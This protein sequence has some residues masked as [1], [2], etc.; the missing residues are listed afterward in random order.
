MKH[1]FIYGPPGSGKSTISK[2]LADQLDLPFLDLDAEIERA[3]G[4]AIP[5]IMTEQ[6]EPAFRD[7]ET[8]ALEKAVAGEASIIALG[9]GALLRD[10]NRACAESDG[11]VVLLEA[12]LPTLLARTKSASGQRP[13][14]VGDVEE[15]LSALMTRRQSHY[16]SFDLR[17]VNETEPPRSV[18]RE[19]QQKLGRFH[20]C[21]MGAG[22]DVLVKTGGLNGLGEMLQERGLGGPIALVSDSNVAPLYG[23]QVLKS[24]REAGFDTN[25]I[26]IPAGEHNKTFQTVMDMWRGFLEAGLDRKSTVV[27]L[28]GGVTGDLAGFAASTFMRGIAWVGL[29]TSLLAM[30]DSALGGKTGFD[31]PYGKNLVGA[32]HSPRLVLADPEVLQTLPEVEFRSGMAEVVKHGVISDPALFA[33][34]AAGTEAV[35][36]DLADLVRHS[37]AVKI[38]IIEEDPFERGLRAALN[39]GHTVGHAI[40]LVSDFKLR[41]GEAVAIGMVVEAQ[42]AERLGLAKGG[43]SVQIAEA[44]QALGLPVEIP[45]DLPHA[46]ILKAI[47]VDK[48]KAAGVVRFAL[49]VAIGEVRTGV[50]IEDLDQI[51]E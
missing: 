38:R 3:A 8:A 9:G 45:P 37:M 31:L 43:L 11:E 36:K 24:V 28:G 51:F 29:P 50:E 44:L 20:V 41:H 10:A 22:Y 21:G 19:I 33:L 25:L 4:Q 14:L 15:K 1:I 7:L 39:L 17:V 35:K 47:Q 23:E 26:T 46:D 30:S 49:P 32:F 13:L 5:Q 6:G 18:A 48:K 16:E 12:D 34:C 42:L 40:E 27:A 2:I